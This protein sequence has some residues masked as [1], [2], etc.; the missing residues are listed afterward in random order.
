M[1][2]YLEWPLPAI[3]VVVAI[4]VP[5]GNLIVVSVYI[6]SNCPSLTFRLGQQQP[7]VCQLYR[8]EKHLAPAGEEILSVCGVVSRTGF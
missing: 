2:S 6:Q 1:A 3:C 7:V 4:L 5:K 8:R